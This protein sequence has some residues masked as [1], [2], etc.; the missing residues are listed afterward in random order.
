MNEGP[1]TL[2]LLK[3]FKAQLKSKTKRLEKLPLLAS[4]PD[5]PKDLPKTLFDSVYGDEKP[6]P[7]R[8]LASAGSQSAG[9]VARKSHNSVKRAL[10]DTNNSSASNPMVAMMQQMSSM[11]N[12][13]VGGM[14]PMM[15]MMAGM[16]ACLQGDPAANPLASNLQIFGK[17][18]RQAALGPSVE[19]QLS[20]TNGEPEDDSQQSTAT[21]DADPK[22][23]APMSMFAMAHPAS[24]KARS[25]EDYVKIFEGGFKGRAAAKDSTKDDEDADEGQ[26]EDEDVQALPKKR[27]ATAAKAD[28]LVKKA[29]KDENDELAA[30]KPAAPKRVAKEAKKATDPK[31]AAVTKKAAAGKKAAGP[32]G[33]DKVNEEQEKETENK[34]EE[35]RKENSDEMQS[36]PSNMEKKKAAM[37]EKARKDLG[38]KPEPPSPWEGTFFWGSGKIHKNP[39]SAVWRAFVH[40]SDKKDRKVKIGDNETASFHRALEIIEEGMAERGL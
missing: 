18:Q 24:T 17:K 27:P 1:D 33:P 22:K 6:S 5:N 25:P 29:K 9:I 37:S 39:G 15:L 4:F 23:D 26:D 20:L 8:A 21:Q 13:N 10:F 7:P 31:K 19:K 36:V 14:N 11:G 2:A 35:E 3:E 32:K 40:K 38:P 28:S 30:K 16:Q 34:P 12:M